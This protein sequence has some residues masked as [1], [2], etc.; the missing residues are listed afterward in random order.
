MQVRIAWR[1]ESVAL[2]LAVVE[3][4]RLKGAESTA[5]GT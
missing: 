5:P 1:R 4:F 3:Q 2:L